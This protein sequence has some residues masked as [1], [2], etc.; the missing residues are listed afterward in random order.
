MTHLSAVRGDTWLYSAT[1][2][3]A[4]GGPYNLVGCTL[5]FTIKR[6]RADADADAAARLYWVHGG[7]SAGINVAT[8]GLG[9]ATIK[10]T[11]AQTGAMT[12]VG[13]VY[14]LQLKDAAGDVWTVDE[15]TFG[16]RL[17]VTQRVTVP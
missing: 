1:I 17:D 7:A 3:N 5:W 2:P 16:V 10:L 9:V 14:D 11:Q 12:N 15:G 6:N 4:A 8:P 13:Y